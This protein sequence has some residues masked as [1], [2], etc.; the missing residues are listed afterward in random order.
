MAEV[1]LAMARG[2]QGVNKL[3]VIKRLREPDEPELVRMF[4]DEARLAAR[5]NHP[6]IVHTYEIGEAGGEYFIAMEYLEGQPLSE[7]LKRLDVRGGGLSESVV[8][9]IAVQVLKG[10]HYAHEFRDFDGA[11]LGTVHRDVSPQN[12]F[13]TYGGAVKLLD[14]GIAKAALNLTRTESGISKGK[15]RYMSPEQARHTAIDRRSDLFSL[16]IVVWEMLARR[17]LFTGDAFAVIARG[18]QDDIPLLRTVRPDVSE[19]LEA[20]VQKALQVAPDRRYATAEEI[21][22]ELERFLRRAG[23]MDSERDLVCLMDD[24][25]ATTRDAV[26]EQIKACVAKLSSEAQTPTKVPGA[27]PVPWLHGAGAL[28]PAV[29]SVRSGRHSRLARSRWA[30]LGVSLV[31]PAG[32]ALILAARGLPPHTSAMPSDAGS[33][34]PPPA[35]ARVETTPPGAQVEWKGMSFGHTPTEFALD[36]GPQ[37]IVLLRDG[38]EPSVLKVEAKPG[39]TIALAN[40]LRAIPE[41]A[42]PTASVAATSPPVVTPT[43]VRAGRATA[44]VAASATSSAAQPRVRMIDEDTPR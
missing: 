32:L 26:H 4:L 2:I 10:L 1:F 8:A 29:S 30:M 22:L 20:I 39:E 14:F 25:F 23:G 28:S 40:A 3:A 13:L 19:E 43:A 18:S 7:V 15:S 24:V 31:V 44:A 5:L 42:P 6:N 36:P 34:V 27:R 33:P 12:I 17:S 41:S 38:Y 21:R 35:R 11:P 37:V 16:G 9:S